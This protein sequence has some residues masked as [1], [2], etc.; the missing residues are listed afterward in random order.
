MTNEAQ[1][2]SHHGLV[3][4]EAQNCTPRKGWPR[5]I[6]PANGER[7]PYGRL[8]PGAVPGSMKRVEV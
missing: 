1:A 7:C 5:P 8:R 3:S 4:L 2:C 6:W